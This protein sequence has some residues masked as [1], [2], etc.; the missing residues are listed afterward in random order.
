VTTA[1]SGWDAAAPA[2]PT[3]SIEKGAALQPD[4]QNT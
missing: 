2:A 3:I 1:T 4:P